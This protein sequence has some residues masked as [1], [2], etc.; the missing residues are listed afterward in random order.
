M[1]V[2][3]KDTCDNKR[4]FGQESKPGLMDTGSSGVLD[5]R[6]LWVCQ[7]HYHFKAILNKSVSFYINSLSFLLLSSGFF[8][9]S[10]VTSWG[11]SNWWV[12][13]ITTVPIWIVPFVLDKVRAYYAPPTDQQ[14]LGK[15]PIHVWVSHGHLGRVSGPACG[16]LWLHLARVVG[17]VVWWTCVVQKLLSTRS[18]P[19]IISNHIKY[20]SKWHEDF[21]NIFCGSQSF[22]FL[23]L[24]VH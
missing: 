23:H 13:M 7:P 20:S 9:F 11:K 18:P 15:V 21:I 2:C 14:L 10:Q 5:P 17:T 8:S 22:L 3:S 6:H 1:E 19:C 24:F 16:W 12:K 4:E